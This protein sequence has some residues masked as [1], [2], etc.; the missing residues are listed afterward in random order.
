MSYF[1]LFLINLT[2]FDTFELGTAIYSLFFSQLVYFINNLNVNIT[3]LV[4][5][6]NFDLIK[7]HLP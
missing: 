5:A 2:K 3:C 6:I 1:S 4:L 7:T